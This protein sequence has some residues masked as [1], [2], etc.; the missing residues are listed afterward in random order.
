MPLCISRFL[1]PPLPLFHPLGVSLPPRWTRECFSVPLAALGETGAP[2][3]HPLLFFLS[4]TIGSVIAAAL[5]RL[6]GETLKASLSP[7]GR[8]GA[9][10]GKCCVSWSPLL[11]CAS[12]AVSW[13]HTVVIDSPVST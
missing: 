10:L 1:L 8:W 5:K 3:S 11:P 4:L 9:P 6:N 7:A 2:G 13:S 12:L